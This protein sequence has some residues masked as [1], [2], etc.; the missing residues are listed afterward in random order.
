[1]NIIQSVHTNFTRRALLLMLITIMSIG[2]VWGDTETEISSSLS[3]WGD[4][5]IAGDKF[6]SFVSGNYLRLYMDTEQEIK[7][8][9]T[10][11][12]NWSALWTS[13][14]IPVGS[15]LYNSAEKYLQFEITNSS[16]ISEMQDYGI[17]IKLEGTVVKS[18]SIVSIAAD[19]FLGSEA[20]GATTATDSKEIAKDTSAPQ[21]INLSGASLGGVK[22]ARIFLA[23]ASGNALSDQSKLTVT[24]NGNAAV[25]AGSSTKNGVYVYDE[26][27]N[28]DRSK[29]N[30]TLDAGVGNFALYQIKCLL[31]TS[32]GTP[33]EGPTLTKEPDWNLTYTYTFTYPIEEIKVPL[34]VE[35]LLTDNLE[36]KYHDTAEQ[37]LKELSG[38]SSVTSFFGRWYVRDK[39][40]G[41]RQPLK[42]AGNPVKADATNWVIQ[43]GYSGS[44]FNG[45][46]NGCSIVGD[47]AERGNT[48]NDWNYTQMF[49]FLKVFLPTS[50]GSTMLDA[51]DYEIVFECTDEYDGSTPSMKLRY[52]FQFPEIGDFEGEANTGATETTSTQTVMRTEESVTVDVAT[53]ATGAKYARFYVTDAQGN[54]VDPTSLLTV[55]YNGS[56]ATACANANNGFYIYADGST[57]NASQVS[58]RLAAQ[59]AY[60]TYRVVALY[61][62][63][64]VGK[65]YVG[66][67]MVEEPDYDNRHTYAF[68]Y[69]VTT[70]ERE[71]QVEWNATAMTMNANPSDLDADWS[72][73][74]EEL[75]AGQTILWWVENGSGAKQPLTLGTERQ[76]GTWAI[77]QIAPFV[78]T[79]N[80]ARLTDVT[81]IDAGQLESWLNTDI[82]A[83][84]E[85][86]Y[87]DVASYK[88]VCEVYTNSTGTGAPNAR[89]TFSLHKGF[90]G[91]LKST[92]T[93]AVTRIQPGAGD[94]TNTINVA[95]PDGTKY[96]RAW[97]TEADGTVIDPSGKLFIDGGSDILNTVDGWDVGLGKYIYNATALASPVSVT[98]ELTAAE[99]D[100]YNV[101]VVT[102]ADAA[103]ADGSGNVT[104]E[105]DFDTKTTYWFKYPVSAV[106]LNASVEWS[107]QSMALEAPAIVASD[108]LADYLAGIRQ[109]YTMQWY[110]EDADGI[111]PLRS[112]SGRVND[113]WTYNV[114]GDPFTVTDNKAQAVNNANLSSDSWSRWAAPVFYAPKNKTMRELVEKNTRFICKFYEDDETPLDDENLLKM[115]YTVDIDR[116]VQLGRLKYGGVREGETIEK[117]DGENNT[118]LT[119]TAT[120]LTLDLTTAAT[121]F[122]EN[123]GGKL[124]YARVY[125]TKSDGTPVDPT[126][127]LTDSGGTPFTTAANGFYFSDENGITLPVNVKLNL[128]AGKYSFY[129]VVIAMS[130]DAGEGGHI[131]AFAHGGIGVQ[132]TV[133][134][135]YEPD[136]DEIYTIK[137]EE[138]ST[139]P[140]KWIGEDGYKHAKEILVEN[141]TVTSQRLSMSDNLTKIKSEYGVSD[142]DTLAA[143]LHIRWYVT[144]KNDEGDYEK[145]PGSENY[146][147]PVTAGFGHQTESDQGLYWNAVT[148]GRTIYD[149]D[150]VNLLDVTFT[151]PAEGS[152][153]DYRVM[154]VMKYVSADDGGLSSTTQ[155]DDDGSPTKK[156]THEPDMLD[157]QYYYNFFV[158]DASF[159]FVHSY[160]ES[161]H[162][163]IHHSDDGRLNAVVKQLAWDNSTGTRAAVSEDIRQGVHT[164][165][166]DVYVDPTTTSPALLKLPFQDYYGSGN[167]LEP[168]AYIRW[169]DWQT[170]ANNTRLSIAG[171]DAS[172][173]EDK[174]ESNNGSEVS[175]GF[176]MLNNSLNGIK[177]THEK[178]GITFD[179]HGVTSLITIA[180][181]VSKYYDGIYS[182]NTAM[183]ERSDFSAYKKPYL[184]HEPTLSTRYIFNIRPASVIATDIQIGQDKL[185]SKGAD[186]FQ[187]AEDNG[188]VSLAMKD[189][190]TTFSV[191]ANLAD[192]R[193]YYLNNGAALLQCTKLQW[194]AYYEDEN[195]IY[196]NDTKLAT[197]DYDE[198]K[199]ISQIRV[200]AL[201][202]T[203]THITSGASK[204]VTA[205]AGQRYHLVGYIGNGTQ[206]SPVVHYEINL[207]DAP[208]YVVSELPLE[209]TEAYLS[210]HMKLQDTVN[211]DG[212]C[213]LPLTD[214]LDSQKSN[215]SLSP[216]DWGMA[217]YGFCYPDVRRIWTGNTD[218]M[219]ISP[220]H[221]DYMLLRSMNRPGVSESTTYD[222]TY[223]WWD[224][225]ELYDYTYYYGMENS[226]EYGSF[227]YVDASD[228]SRTIAK[229]SFEASLCAGSELCFTGVIANMSS[230]Q[231]QPQVMTTVYAVK[232]DGTS[233]RVVSFHSSDLS[234]VVEGSYTKGKWYQVYGRTAIPA[235]VNLTNVDHYEVYIDNYAP[236]TDGADYCVD[237]LQFYT[238]TAKLKVK[239]SVVNCGDVEMPL[240]IYVEAEQIQSM[241]GKSIFWRI[242]DSEGNA[243]TD[244]NLYKNGDHLYG[245]T[246]VPSDIPATIPDEASLPYPGSGYFTSTDGILYFSLAHRGFALKEGVEYYISAYSM[247]ETAVVYESLWGSPNDECSVFSPVFIPKKM[248]LTVTDDDDA[249]V[250]TVKGSCSENKATINLNVV[251]N[252]PDANEVS[253][254]KQYSGIHYDYFL[255]T[256]AEANGYKITVDET[257][258]YLTDALAHYR[259]RD[260]SGSDT[261]K[262]TV[263]LDAGYESVN[264]NYYDVLKQ[265]VDGGKLF[266]NYSSEIQLTIQGD[267]ENNAYVAVLP[268]EMRVTNDKGEQFLVCTPLEYVFTIDNSG[269][270]PSIVLGFE[271]VW[272]YPDGIRTVRVGKEQIDNLQKSGGFFLH[273]PVNTFKKNDD[274][275]EKNGTLQITSDVGLLAYSSSANQ[276]SDDQITAN[277]N[278]VATFVDTEITASKM[279]ISLNFHGDDVEKPV[280][281]E[282]FAY[283]M[284]F[285][286]RGKDDDTGCDGSTEFLLKV[287]PEFVTWNGNS[288]NWNDDSNWQRSQRA[289][290]YKGAK[291][292]TTNTATSG[293]P[294]G[295]ENNGEGSLASVVTTP[296]TYVPMK[297]TY[298]TLPSGLR[299]PN[300]SYL[301]DESNKDHGI[302]DYTESGDGLTPATENIQYDLLVRYTE[303]TCQGGDNHDVVSGDIYDCE[304]FYG[305][306]CRELYLKPGAELV[307]QQWLTYEKVW[308]E[309]ELTANT[310]TLMSTPLKDTYAGDMYVPVSDTEADNGRQV[311]EAFQPITFST[312]TNAAGFTYSRTQYPIYQKGWTQ[313]GVYVKTKT[314][315][316]RASQYSA[317]IPGGV[318]L[319]LNQWSHEYNDVTVPYSTWT[320]F[321]IRPHKK[322]QAAKTLIRLPKAD[323]SYD[324]YQWD[325]TSPDGGKLTEAVTK[326][327]IGRLLTDG[328]TT[329]DE[330]NHGKISHAISAVQS[331][332][333]N[334]QLVGN[335]YLCTIDMKEFLTA[336]KSNLEVDGYWTYENNN[337]GSAITTGYIAPMQSF[338]VKAKEGATNIIFNKDMMVDGH[339][340][341]P[342]PAK[343]ALTLT[344]ENE[345]GRSKASVMTGEGQDLETLFDSNLSNVPIVY[346]VADGQAV[347]INRSSLTPQ[348]PS[349]QGGNWMGAFLPFGVVCNSQEAIDVT[350]TGVDSMEG[351]LYVVDAL[352]GMQ[353]EVTEGQ[354]ITVEPNEYGRYFLVSG[355][356]TDIK[357]A[358]DLYSGIVASVR[359]GQVTLSAGNRLGTV[360]VRNISGATVYQAADC[361]NSVQLRLQQDVYVIET[362]GEAGKKT[363]KI[364]VR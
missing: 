252:M 86:S 116:Q 120:S 352:S 36:L 145:I 154:I 103:V 300:L 141:E 225:H 206:M 67:T 173:L 137:F 93:T 54:A 17:Y 4:N 2:N 306:T 135:V 199:R 205:A 138:T 304:K 250:T 62:T 152:W 341:S 192:L 254:F 363:F 75:A 80:V 207:M 155:T 171:G 87:A 194:Y 208:A 92:A 122:A 111:Q 310:W 364:I 229:M 131:G 71:P 64:L 249:S 99:L 288:N 226:G 295:Y 94:I 115:T 32:T 307:N 104:S 47:A 10:K 22:Y 282:G 38:S 353:T 311:S 261:Y 296:R 119:S 20:T 66:G 329:G 334:Y 178:V 339:S 23:D 274:A 140:G 291:G 259:N 266:L 182:C 31:S 157:M 139:F 106:T 148:S 293:H 269:N 309:K 50:V 43:M 57:L 355:T 68:D 128:D 314:N 53:Q 359:D 14:S 202:G 277:I 223:H 82:Y 347:S 77:G 153:E 356:V 132:N 325:N 342:A 13:K 200:S 25:A 72:T 318:S 85:A 289:E 167:N 63:A 284:F 197:L 159:L 169:Y 160:G 237:Q 46:S 222:Y 233:V 262:T 276:T 294:D 230:G 315:D 5:Y 130:G 326:T 220:L 73:S 264:K 256:L 109:H 60:K 319:L 59:K 181:D 303:K 316:V 98:L 217:Q 1:M 74:L 91:S 337:T 101:V 161:F 166:Y 327:N 203:Y 76:N 18:V 16:V 190:N 333:A 331:S 52:V 292:S 290:L 263:G 55:T 335:P 227:L 236:G 49:G 83:P 107:A 211:F 246:E 97:L 322:S 321:A 69:T 158:E 245:T 168:V 102:S 302:Y 357:Q 221:G 198:T 108:E 133:K 112:G 204:E 268:A 308:V 280:F 65:M 330:D 267:A 164:V 114:N 351:K 9:A 56:A 260:G 136:Y 361:G 187:L 189:G 242:C 27:N 96:L 24:Y 78:V 3:T 176:F 265:A 358:D 281:R 283:R 70:Y 40:T 26:G 89:Y 317:N 216:L 39:S 147:T 312:E 6:S 51:S 193:G 125:L 273:I 340:Y 271:D 45:D 191:R 41:V 235:T 81:S 298:V 110:V 61:S 150:Q 183:D 165:E 170:D 285:Q 299:A 21:V 121:S 144:K 320:A 275:T 149:S 186:M 172:Y 224:G 35:D 209:R 28:L 348:R 163:F 210:A 151:K 177:P 328:T 100:Q 336:N 270:A 79:S 323:A 30:I 258:Y 201:S 279:Y 248:Y 239:Q 238:S 184:M 134:E 338:F 126:D 214:G 179:P 313:Q 212:E 349:P 33:A 287:V 15:G 127:L 95:L 195:G 37:K 42:F 88:I 117:D 350:L 142:L 58:V 105:P 345:H 278:K 174:V 90:V 272:S 251:L 324:Y 247:G 29:V 346:T 231:V 362:D 305:N 175:R 301:E 34:L 48:T 196:F 188:R 84:L 240:N 241:A 113:Y 218:Y 162:D 297:F 129:N 124:R 8:I 244:D 234:T 11:G 219:G 232:T 343:A 213:G 332:P 143:N 123:V 257:D 228:E 253:G 12:G 7:E 156:L 215:H 19:T 360:R 255:G 344:A 185:E 44:W 286:F 354:T 118:G 243:L 180:C 146:L